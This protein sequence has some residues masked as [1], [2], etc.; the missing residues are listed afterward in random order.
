VQHRK[1][2]GKAPCSTVHA[3]GRHRA[4]PYTQRTGTVQHRTRSGQ[5]HTGLNLRGDTRCCPVRIRRCTVPTRCVYGTAHTA[6]RRA[7]KMKS[8]NFFQT[9]RR[10][11]RCLHAL[12]TLLSAVCTLRVRRVH[13]GHRARATHQKP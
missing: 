7:L 5:Q 12:C 4:A 3:A 9:P 8:F 2:S 13:G 10:C 11:S 1:R 6:Q